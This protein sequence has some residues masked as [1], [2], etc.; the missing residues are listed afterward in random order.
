MIIE[1]KSFLKSLALLVEHSSIVIR[2]K[3]LLCFLLLF[4]M[5][6]FW[7]ILVNE[8]KLYH[9][10]DRLVR[11]N[12]KY[13]Q[14]CL[15]CLVENVAEIVPTIQKAIKDEFTLFIKNGADNLS[16][17][18]PVALKATTA[19]L[20]NSKLDFVNLK[21]NMVLILSLLDLCNA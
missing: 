8:I 11:D 9:V 2:G 16:K 10:L 5:S 7:L 15:L 14:L 13:V 20:N 4:K 1:E 18:D 12:F 3:T 6:P 21:G 17:S 19:Y